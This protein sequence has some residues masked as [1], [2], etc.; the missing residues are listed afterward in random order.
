MN[1]AIVGTGYVGLVTGTCFA[2][3]GNDVIC[4][5]I[6][7][8]KVQQL[9]AGELPIYEPDLDV[10]FHRNLRE[11]RLRFTTELA[12]AVAVSEFLFLALPTPPDED[13][14]ADLS[15]VLGVAEQIAALLR[16]APEPVYTILVN[17]STVPVGTADK[18]RRILETEGLE[19][20]RD[21]DVV[22]NPEFLREGAAVIDF[23]KP[24]RVVIGASS[25][26]AAQR[27]RLL[28]EPFVR[29]GNPIY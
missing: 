10:Y 2:E 29:Q 9:R 5:D 7:A 27:M 3:M 4:V 20:G 14:G 6:D 18:V 19:A 22:S 13:G 16:Q 28:Y 1:I 11:G 15:Y 25:E 23:M 26:R 17:K 21:F 8:Q 24:E 12:E